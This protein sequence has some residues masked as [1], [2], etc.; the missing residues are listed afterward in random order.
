MKLTQPR[1]WFC[2]IFFEKVE[3]PSMS[4]RHSFPTSSST[5]DTRSLV[6]PKVQSNVYGTLSP[7]KNRHIL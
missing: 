5:V 2:I 6:P 7:E 3:W 4:Y 1:L